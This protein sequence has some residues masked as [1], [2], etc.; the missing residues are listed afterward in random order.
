LQVKGNKKTL[1]QNSED[2]FAVKKVVATDVN[3]D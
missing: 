2:S 1:L 3:M